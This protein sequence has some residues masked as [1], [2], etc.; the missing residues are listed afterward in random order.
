MKKRERRRV[1]PQKVR[2]NA[3][4]IGGGGLTWLRL[5]KGRNYYQPEKPGVVRLNFLPYE[6]KVQ[7]HPDRV[8]QGTLWYKRPFAVHRSIGVG[9]ESVVCPISVGKRCP[10]CEQRAKLAKNYKENE[11]VIGGLTAQKWVAYNVLN[12]EDQDEVVV[13][14]F[15]RGKFASF[16]ET[17]L[18]E[19]DESNLNFYD[20]TDEGKT[21][22]VRFSDDVYDGNKFIK[23]TR[24]DFI[25]R[26][27][28]DE[29]DILGKVIC[30][31]DI[32]VVKEYDEIKRLFEG[33]DDGSGSEADDE[34]ADD[35][36]DEPVKKPVKPQAKKKVEDDDDEDDDDEDDD[37]ERPAK[38]P[39]KKPVDDED[40]EDVEDSDEDDGDD[41]PDL[42]KPVPPKSKSGVKSAKPEPKSVKK[43]V[44]DDDD[45][46][47]DDEDED[48]DDEDDEG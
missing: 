10:I 4:E 20:V 15:S 33:A 34:D 28:M 1:D 24:I 32:F 29:D 43:P 27:P 42:P 22:K 6:V 19:G 36:D 21:L 40:A 8:D 12:P 39:V 5:P 45:D 41:E 35:D 14:V 2:T 30:L 46:D 3:A 48:D 16:L 17:E 9:G 25:P 44:D 23:T 7:N 11:E 47:D 26:E 37:D 13:F 31:D 38:K 18:Q